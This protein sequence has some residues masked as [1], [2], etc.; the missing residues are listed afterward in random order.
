MASAQT[1]IAE[2]LQIHDDDPVKA[3]QLLKGIVFNELDSGGQTHFIWPVNHVNGELLSQWATAFELLAT[4]RCED[5]VF[6]FK[7]LVVAAYCSGQILK[8]LA[9]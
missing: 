3:G 6:Y 5:S 4:N 2:A 1:L 8:A 7:S 9:G